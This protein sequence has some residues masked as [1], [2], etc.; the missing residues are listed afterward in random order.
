MSDVHATATGEASLVR[1]DETPYERL[2]LLVTVVSVGLVL[3][4]VAVLFGWLPLAD[5]PTTRVFGGLLVL[6]GLSVV[7]FGVASRLDAVDTNPDHAA[8]V[9]TGLGVGAVTFATVALA[10]SQTF[11]VGNTGLLWYLVWGAFGVGAAGVVGLSAATSVVGW[12]R[13]R[14]DASDRTTGVVGA[15]SLVAA[16]VGAGAMVV[17]FGGLL[18]PATLA[19]GLFVGVPAVALVRYDR[20][21]AVLRDGAVVL[22]GVGGLAGLYYGWQDAAGVF[23]WSALGFLGAA[24]AVAATLG[25]R[26][27]VGSTLPTGLFAVFVGAVFLTGVIGPSWVWDVTN[28]PHTASTNAGA[29]GGVT[30]TVAVPGLTILA[31][32]LVGWAAAKARAGFGAEGRERGAFLLM[33]LNA[34]AMI[35]AMLFVVGFVVVRGAGPALKGS[36]VGVGSLTVAELGVSVPI[37][38]VRWPFV[39]LGYSFVPE[40]PNGILP[41]LLGTFWIVLGAVLIGVPLAVG[42]AVYLSEFAEQSGFTRV[43]ETATN[44]LWSTPSVVYGL[45]A[46]SFI[47]LELGISQSILAGQLVLAFMLIPLVLIT[48]REAII[49]VPDE[50]RD[51]SAALGVTKWQTIRSVVLPAAMPGILTGVILGIGRIAG[52]TAP[53]LLVVSSRLNAREAPHVLRGFRFVGEPPFIANDALL[54]S[55]GAL[56]LRIWTIISHGVSAPIEQG[57]GAAFVLLLLVLSFYAVGIAMRKHFRRKLNHE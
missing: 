53:I 50:Y 41:P 33:Y 11:G 6:A 17:G 51:A 27:D 18:P 25:P 13:T 1:D 22:A 26:E 47:V 57:W 31:A 39:E 9:V 46:F 34:G 10:A 44:A 15:A 16:A 52:E 2:T 29:G 19:A 24:V 21:D 38:D 36:S 32:V 30:G 45:F 40:I 35:G 55:S 8:G 3:A 23:G 4:P 28:V 14:F 12:T 56:P 20:R 43:V 5:A 49:A 42:A 54:S 48:A 7:G 37:L